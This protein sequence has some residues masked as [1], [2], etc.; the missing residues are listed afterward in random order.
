MPRV[1]ATTTSRSLGWCTR[2]SG[3]STMT[4]PCRSVSVRRDRIVRS[5]SRVEVVAGGGG[6]APEAAEGAF[7]ASS[8]EDRKS[9]RLNSSH[10]KISYAVFCVKKK[11]VK[12]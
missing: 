1:E 3:E 12:I 2:V 10:V 7:E 4:T 11:N 8:S 5:R 9:T 6:V